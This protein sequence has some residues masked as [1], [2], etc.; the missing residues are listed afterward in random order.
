MSDKEREDV[1][2]RI[3]KLDEKISEHRNKMSK[4]MT[5]KK[6]L[7]MSTRRSE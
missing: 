2:N 6:L 7:E 3:K 5:E 1:L 4:Y